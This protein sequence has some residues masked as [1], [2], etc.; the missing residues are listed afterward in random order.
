MTLLNIASI[1]AL[2]SGALNILLGIYIY[3]KAFKNSANRI[4]VI[5]TFATAVWSLINAYYLRYTWYPN[6]NFSYA[7]G[8]FV[9]LLILIWISEFTQRKFPRYVLYMFSIGTVIISALTLIPNLVIQ[10]KVQ[11]LNIG[12]QIFPGPLFTLF[13]AYLVF[14]FALACWV[15]FVQWRTTTGIRRIQYNYIFFAIVIPTTIIVII[16][17]I[18]PIFKIFNYA[19]FDSILSLFFVSIIGYSITRYRF[20]DIKVV[21]KKGLVH[22]ISIAIVLFLYVYLLIFGQRILVQQYFWSEQTT[23]I[24]LVLIIVLTLEPMR[25]LVLKSVDLVFYPEK[26]GETDQQNIALVLST[27][28]KLETLVTHLRKELGMIAGVSDVWF[29]LNDRKLGSLV[30]YPDGAGNDKIKSSDELARHLTDDTGVIVFDELPYRQEEV[31]PIEADRLRQVSKQM[32]N[33]RASL[34]MPVGEKGDLIGAFFFGQKAG[35]EAYTS[36]VIKKLQD[37]QRPVTAALANAL[38]YKQAVERIAVLNKH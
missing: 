37:L 28:Q 30:G 10:N 5:L 32:K 6:I 24:W 27:A 13:A 17:F 23:T 8:I 9:P 4:F 36:D 11:Q 7:I 25:R 19:T 18:L 21:I 22:F 16:D 14:L 1:L 33:I 12:F 2:L 31:D 3:K 15:L 35:K 38:F 34:A 26:E 20:L 29:L